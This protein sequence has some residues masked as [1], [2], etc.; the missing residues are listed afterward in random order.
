MITLMEIAVY[1]AVMSGSSS[2]TCFGHGHESVSCSN[3]LSAEVVT[4]TTIVYS[5]GVTVDVSGSFP[6][7]SDGTRNWL[8]SIGSVTFSTGMHVRR[9]TVDDFKFSSGLECKTQT[10]EVV[11]CSLPD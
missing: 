8:D 5:N 6:V 3:V 11:Q 7:F 2:L 1:A 10:P 9:I 4:P